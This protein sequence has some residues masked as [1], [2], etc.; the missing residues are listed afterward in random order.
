M[1]ANRISSVHIFDSANWQMK[2]QP[3]SEISQS[4]NPKTD[5]L[6]P[7]QQQKLSYQEPHGVPIISQSECSIPVGAG[8]VVGFVKTGQS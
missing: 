8:R 2:L 5:Q 6:W 4:H 1:R 3:Y 7:Q